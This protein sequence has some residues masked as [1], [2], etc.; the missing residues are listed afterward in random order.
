MGPRPEGDDSC[1]GGG[2]SSGGRRGSTHGKRGGFRQEEG[3]LPRGGS[4]AS[5]RKKGGYLEVDRGL[6]AGRRGASSRWIGGFPQEEGGLPRGGSGASDRKE[7]FFLREDAGPSGWKK[8]GNV[9]ERKGLPGNGVGIGSDVARPAGTGDALD[10][11]SSAGG[12]GTPWSSSGRRGRLRRSPVVDYSAVASAGADRS[13]P[14]RPIQ[15]TDTIS[16][17]GTKPRRAGRWTP[18]DT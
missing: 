18:D 17:V 9:T 15:T 16:G 3:G 7:G 13:L 10:T 12:P 6:P 11:T 4:R 1:R 5:G 14:H 2:W 8:G